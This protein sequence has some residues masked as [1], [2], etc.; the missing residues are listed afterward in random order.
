MVSHKTDYII[1]HCP[2]NMFSVMCNLCVCCTV[3]FLPVRA[4]PVSESEA[5]GALPAGGV[6]AGGEGA[7]EGAQSVGTGGRLQAAEVDAGHD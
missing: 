5:H 1:K 3:P 4:I 6:A 7:T 2:S